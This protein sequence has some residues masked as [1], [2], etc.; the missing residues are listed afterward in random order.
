[1]AQ[2]QQP[3][4][5][6][7]VHAAPAT[8]GNKQLNTAPYDHTTS[9]NDNRAGSHGI[10]RRR[11][12][13][14]VESW[15]RTLQAWLGGG[16][17]SP[18]LLP[19]IEEELE[20]N[21]K[22]KELSSHILRAKGDIRMPVFERWLLDSKVLEREN[23]K[24][25]D[26]VI[27]VATNPKSEPS[28]W[29]RGELLRSSEHDS[30]EIDR[31][32]SGLCRKTNLACQELLSRTDSYKR[33]SPLKKGDRIIME[34]HECTVTILYSR[35]K[36]KKPFCFKLNKSHYEKLCQRF[37][38]VHNQGE[39]RLERK[40]EKVLHS[41]NVMVLALLLRYSALSGTW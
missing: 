13:E 34:D 28:I 41:F 36:W 37:F 40:N 10:K 35:K 38:E 18:G 4:I 17:Y 31:M 27:P 15:N 23:K 39:T 2:F 26:P 12:H 24:S 9:V 19:N 30:D 7:A 29:L 3:D 33:Q 8:Q 16:Q 25:L 14:K 1:M 22:V 6:P 21:F 11:G 32:V 5:T 20:R